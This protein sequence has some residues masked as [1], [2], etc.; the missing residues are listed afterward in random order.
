MKQFIKN[1][2]E[3]FLIGF[4]LG[5]GFIV[6]TNLAC[7]LL[8]GLVFGV[9]WRLGGMGLW[10]TKAWRRVGIP[11]LLVIVI[12]IPLLLK[13]VL[14]G[15]TFGILTVGYGTRSLQPPDEG[16]ILGN[17]CVS[18]AGEVYGKWLARLMIISGI[19]LVWA[20]AYLWK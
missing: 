5:L 1:N 11:V 20:I 7:G 18:V 13:M 15:I 2:W 10:G 9:L 17:W 14:A 3:E 12:C 6:F 19:W 8:L 4:I 16:T